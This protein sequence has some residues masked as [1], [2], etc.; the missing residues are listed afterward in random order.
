MRLF[1]AGATGVLGRAVV[2]LAVEQ[3]HEVRGLARSSA[4]EALLRRLGA[5]PVPG[6]LF[7]V[8]GLGDVMRGVDAVLH[9]ATRIP[10]RLRPSLGDF[11][12]NNRIRTEGTIKLLEGARL[13][14][15]RLYIQQSIAFIAARPEPRLLADDAPCSLPAAVGT[16]LYAAVKMEDLVRHAGERGLQTVVLRGGFFYHAES[17]QTRSMVDAI[18]KRLFPIFGPGDNIVS[19]IH[20][21]D[22]ARAVLAVLEKPAPGETFFVVD[23]TPLE[24]KKLIGT[25]AGLVGAK[26][27]L[28][29]PEFLARPALGPVLGVLS[30]IS[31]R[32]SNV[33]LK[34]A[35]GW[36]P[37]YP[38]PAVGMRQVL[39]AWN[40]NPGTR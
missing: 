37:H 18:R 14:G 33:K 15:A 29:F 4:N 11:A 3:S 32:C 28:H 30:K 36:E 26:P 23:D 16:P 12:E 20:V 5:K 31:F 1:I 10:D 13:G 38:D 39:A 17:T 9:L 34:H 35:T 25:I 40:Q 2:R 7:D 22:M 24:F 8:R 19:S 6:N 27:P 21:D